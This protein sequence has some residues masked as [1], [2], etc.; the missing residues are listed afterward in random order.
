VQLST[1]RAAWGPCLRFLPLPDVAGLLSERAPVAVAGSQQGKE[2]RR[3]T[4]CD[5]SEAIR[6]VVITTK[7]AVAP[8]S[9][10]PPRTTSIRATAVSRIAGQTVA[11]QGWPPA[12]R[13]LS[14]AVLTVALPTILLAAGCGGSGVDAQSAPP[15]TQPSLASPRPTVT[16]LTEQQRAGQAAAARVP[17]YERLLSE[18]AIHR[19]MSLNKLY[20]VSTQPDVNEEISSL[21]VFRESG[22][23]QTG[24][25]RVVGARVD[26]VSLAARPG[27][28]HAVRP[29]VGITACV[30]VRG[31][32]GFAPNGRSIVPRGRKA[33][34]LTHLTL[35]NINYP[36]PSKWRVSKVTDQEDRSC[37]L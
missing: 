26:H 28:R 20:S 2:R 4:Q 17:I 7:G 23:R 13:R 29:T 37:H 24:L 31:V 12:G 15:T 22:D 18:L 34:L 33:Y 14:N 11:P 30:D 35:V 36:D 25:G 8:M 27:A 32:H 6:D 10:R 5:K 16:V 19:K 3:L 1:D 9:R 21:N